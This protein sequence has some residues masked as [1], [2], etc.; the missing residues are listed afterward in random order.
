[1]RAGGRPVAH[2]HAGDVQ[3]PAPDR[4]ES[5]LL[6]AS[7]AVFAV[8][9]LAS[10]LFVRVVWTAAAAPATLMVPSFVL[11]LLGFALA[12]LARGSLRTARLLR[13]VPGLLEPGEETRA[14]AV[15][16][17]GFGPARS[18]AMLAATDE[19]LVWV[20][21]DGVRS[22]AYADVEEVDADRTRGHLRLR[23]ADGDLVLSPVPR[24][25]MRIL[26]TLLARP[27]AGRR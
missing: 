21:R 14:V 13:R 7:L 11:L 15:R 19:R 2:P 3:K 24:R 10:G 16:S 22:F 18:L 9:E 8:V 1:L 12:I 20:E 23:L 26:R 25:E 6:G 4:A 5:T 17:N 27:P